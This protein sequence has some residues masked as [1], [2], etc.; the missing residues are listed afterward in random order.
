VDLDFLKYEGEYAIGSPVR[1]SFQSVHQNGYWILGLFQNTRVVICE[2]SPGRPVTWTGPGFMRVTEGDSLTFTIDDILAAMYYDIVIR[3]EPQVSVHKINTSLV[4]SV[5]VNI[6][7]LL[8]Q[9]S[10]I[11]TLL[12]EDSRWT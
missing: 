7:K 6:D 2:P 4:S 9:V 12:S 5:L 1:I 8:H 11:I 10:P 3:Y